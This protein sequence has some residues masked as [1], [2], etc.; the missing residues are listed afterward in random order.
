MLNDIF[1]YLN[2]EEDEI[3]ED[4]PAVQQ[5]IPAEETDSTKPEPVTADAGSINNAASTEE[6]SAKLEEVAN[7]AAEPTVNGTAP[8]GP[9]QESPVKDI[10]P[11][12]PEETEPSLPAENP[13]E[14]EPTPA[15]SPLPATSTPVPEAE[16]TSKTWANMV[17]SKAAAIPAGPSPALPAASQSK[18]IPRS[19]PAPLP[20][21]AQ[22]GVTE[23]PSNTIV[24]SSDEWQTA[25]HGRKQSKPQNKSTNEGNV[26][27]Y[28]KNVT[29]KIE[30]SA[31]RNTLEKCGELKYF[32]IS[33]PKVGATDFVTS[34]GISNLTEH[35][36]RIV[37]L[38]NLQPRPVIALPSRLILTRLAPNRSM[39]KN[40][41]LGRMH[42][43]A[44]TP[45]STEVGPV[46]DGVVVLVELAAEQAK[47]EVM[48]KMQVVALF[49]HVVAAAAVGDLVT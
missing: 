41:V 47:V 17:G 22:G 23:E 5:S 19:S 14:P 32:D 44:A 35:I 13:A 16:S 26:L 15:R 28:I 27:G 31:L 36:N 33:R 24:S 37:H 40:V 21:T 34:P 29:E 30:A 12:A 25:D 7:T 39:W 48:P 45:A 49:R 18:A 9:T 20:T 4:E 43:V 38:W 3:I 42:L 8:E 2:D 11:V 1:R 6:V 10:S 46:L